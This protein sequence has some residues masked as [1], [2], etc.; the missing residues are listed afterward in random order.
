LGNQIGESTLQAAISSFKV[1]I[2]Y[3]KE[4][5]KDLMSRIWKYVLVGIGISAIPEHFIPIK[6][7]ILRNLPKPR[8]IATFNGIL[9]PD[10]FPSASCLTLS[11]SKRAP[12]ENIQKPRLWLLILH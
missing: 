10:L 6:M 3:A 4:L 8:R 11:S 9:L 7:I 12:Y 2:D 1:R 5:A